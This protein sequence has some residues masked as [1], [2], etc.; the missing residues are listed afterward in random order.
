[1]RAI[2]SYFV[3][4]SDMAWG[5]AMDKANRI[6]ASLYKAS[7]AIGQNID[8]ARSAFQSLAIQTDGTTA[9]IEAAAQTTE[10]LLMFADITGVSVGGIASEWGMMEKGI[11]RTRGQLFKMLF[12]TG[13]FGKNMREASTYW[14]K[15]R[16][17][18]RTSSMAKAMGTIYD[19]FAKAPQTMASVLV[20]FSALKQRLLDVVG[21]NIIG[22]LTA[23]FDNLLQT[24]ESKRPQLEAIAARFGKFLGAHIEDALTWAGTKLSYLEDHWDEIVQGAEDGAKAILKA[25][26][27]IVANKE[28]ILMAYGLNVMAPSI[29]V[30][31]QAASTLKVMLAGLHTLS[32]ASLPAF[33]TSVNAA[34]LAAGN[35][36]LKMGAVAAAALAV[37]MAMDQFN[38]LN[39]EGGFKQAWQEM[40]YGGQSYSDADVN[41]TK[42]A[43]TDQ[44]KGGNLQSAAQMI[45]DKQASLANMKANAE[46]RF[47]KE[48]AASHYEAMGVTAMENLLAKFAKDLPTAQNIAFAE[49][50][51][52]Q[53]QLIENYNQAVRTG[54]DAM[55]T[56][57]ANL[58]GK[59]EEL[60][61]GLNDSSIQIEGGFDGFLNRL[62]TTTRT[63]VDRLSNMY[64]ETNPQKVK[65]AEAKAKSPAINMSGG[66]TFNIKQEFREAD[67][68]RIALFF[69]RD[70][71]RAATSRT[72]SRVRTPFGA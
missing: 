27:F 66:Q 61:Y 46:V 4:G 68:D 47:G 2:A 48:D 32:F 53:S 22:I 9:S 11:V 30:G 33:A 59:S 70:L 12:S 44:V 55:A 24:L 64:Q 1:M 58:A 13:I 37:Y 34:A 18:Q 29:Q 45:A 21:V 67:P 14:G 65:P 16:D 38:K 51:N 63:F 20:S 17:E 36:A 57:L 8:D 19:R 7:I 25:V 5:A 15:L 28:L 71:V 31:L 42:T 40:R 35:V 54:N 3:T 56:Y 39:A 43:I 41:A 50:V 26:Q 60:A 72:R 62:G 23:K 69:R 52:S 10:K 6:D 49:T